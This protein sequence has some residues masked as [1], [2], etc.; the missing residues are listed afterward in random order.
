MNSDPHQDVQPVLAA[1]PLRAPRPR[2]PRSLRRVQRPTME[3]GRARAVSTPRAVGP[4]SA[5]GTRSRW[6]SAHNGLPK[7]VAHASLP[8][9]GRALGDVRRQSQRGSVADFCP[10]RSP[11]RT[12]LN[13][14]LRRAFARRMAP[15]HEA[16][17]SPT[18]SRHRATVAIRA[19]LSGQPTSRSN[20]RRTRALRPQPSP[21]VP[22]HA[23]TVS[24]LRCLDIEGQA[25]HKA[26][27]KYGAKYLGSR[28]RSG[29][30]GA[31][32]PTRP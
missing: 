23:T 9:K 14:R 24:R 22:S 10:T 21:S 2:E 1:S 4:G 28:G 32:K 11:E 30:V 17:E 8:A 20:R 26:S 13:A 6:R 15:P 31:W 7:E 25:G 29:T 27:E 16:G 18:G 3:R 5:L 12:L 19:D